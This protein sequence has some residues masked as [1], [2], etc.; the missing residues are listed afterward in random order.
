[1]LT[2]TMFIDLETYLIGHRLTP[3][4]VSIALDVGEGPYIELENTFKKAYALMEKHLQAGGVLVGHNVS[5]DLGC[6]CADEP[7][8]IPIIFSAYKNGQIKDTMV[9]EKLI[10]ISEDTLGIRR[11]SLSALVKK[12]FGVDLAGK[13]GDDI[14]RKRYHELDGTPIED[15][16]NEAKDYALDDVNWTRKVYNA[17]EDP[18]NEDP[19]T[20]SAWVLHLISIYGMRINKEQSLKWLDSVEIDAEKGKAAAQALGILRP[21]GTRNMSKLRELVKS[22]YGDLAPLTEK[23]SVKT[24]GDTL[25]NSSNPDLIKFAETKFAETLYTRY[26]PIL[27]GSRTV[28]PSYNVLVKSGRTSCKNPNMQNPPREGGF[29]ECFEPRPGYV[30][31]LCDYDQIE[32][33]ALAQ[34]HKWLFNSSTIADA[35]NEGR[36]IHL[37][38]AAKLNPDDPQSYRQFAKIANYGFPGGLSAR[39]FTSY[40][41]SFG[42]DITEEQSNDIRAAWLDT[43]PEMRQYFSYIS[44]QTRW[45]STEIEQYLSG[46]IRGGCSFT[47][48]ANTYFQ[49]LVADGAKAALVRISEDCYTNPNSPLWESRPVAFL[50]DEI[51]LESP[52]KVSVEAAE[53]LGRLMVETMKEY[54]PDVLVEATPYL[55]RQ[56]SKSA[57]RVV[58]NGKLTPWSPEMTD[59]VL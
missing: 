37:E 24:D 26:A 29:R 51:I 57:K 5:F 3:R 9:R 58:V 45:G 56:W 55:S 6:V 46:R 8:M 31:V 2:K 11:F 1:M 39:V 15:W 38:V 43:W 12:Y 42:L 7:K 30:Y 25:K 28:H 4:I 10:A 40:A 33:V 52:E 50:H 47:Q 16:P 21:N 44:K 35:I 41:K 23:G 49:G 59:A 18:I 27:K 53:E 48:C 36:D 20:Y 34:I 13:E 17:Q 54:I 19:Q 22:A 14:W 32:L